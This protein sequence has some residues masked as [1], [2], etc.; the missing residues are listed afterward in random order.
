MGRYVLTFESLKVDPFDASLHLTD[1]T[2]DLDSASAVNLLDLA[3]E[4]KN[5]FKVRV[6][7]LVLDVESILSIYFI[8]KLNIEDPYIE[9]LKVAGEKQKTHETLEIYLIR[10]MHCSKRKVNISFLQKQSWFTLRE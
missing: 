2:L 10:Q 8:S 6:S 4:V 9:M 1:F 7:T 3:M 5:F